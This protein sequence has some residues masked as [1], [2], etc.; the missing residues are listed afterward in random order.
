MNEYAEKF[1]ILLVGKRTNE[2]S[3]FA[4]SL[5]LPPC[6]GPAYSFPFERPEAERRLLPSPSLAS[7]RHSER[8]WID[9]KEQ[10]RTEEGAKEALMRNRRIQSGIRKS[11]V[12]C[13][14]SGDAFRGTRPAAAAGR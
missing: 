6:R 1:Q 9:P 13:T 14:I 8:I 10:R 7:Y 4:A 2:Y 11:V 3:R 12:S 5:R